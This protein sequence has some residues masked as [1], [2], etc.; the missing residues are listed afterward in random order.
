MTSWLTGNT[1]MLGKTEGKR[2][3]G[4]WQRMRWLDSITD[5]MNMNL[6]KLQEIVKNREACHAVV[7]GITMSQTQLSKWTTTN[8][9]PWWDGSSTASQSPGPRLFP[10]GCSLS[11]RLL[12]LSTW[13]KMV[14]SI[15][16]IQPE[17]RRRDEKQGL[18]LLLEV[19]PWR[20]T[21][22]FCTYP[23]VHRRLRNVVLYWVFSCPAKN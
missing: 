16:L 13:L 18:S 4:G 7:H 19:W 20:C 1:L 23:T 10:S 8:N 12:P 5:W 17:G 15:S 22:Q 21:H 3:G 6:N 9:S 2:R 11:P 14:P